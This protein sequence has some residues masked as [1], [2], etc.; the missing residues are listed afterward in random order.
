MRGQGMHAEQQQSDNLMKASAHIKR[1]RGL[2]QFG[3][4]RVLAE[5]TLKFRVVVTVPENNGYVENEFV[6]IALMLTSVKGVMLAPGVSPDNYV[7]TAQVTSVDEIDDQKRWLQQHLTSPLPTFESQVQFRI[8]KA[9]L[10]RQSTQE[11]LRL[12]SDTNDYV[13]D[14]AGWSA[15]EAYADHMVR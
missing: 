12:V 8:T 4:K 1:A 15:L 7:F 14:E 11:I 5:P 10:K 13:T 9:S 3:G 2:L 6:G